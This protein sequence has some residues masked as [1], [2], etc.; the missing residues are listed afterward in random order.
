MDYPW[1]IHSFSMDPETTPKHTIYTYIYIYVYICK[2]FFFQNGSLWESSFS[3]KICLDLTTWTALPSDYKKRTIGTKT[4][5]P[6]ERKPSFPTHLQGGGAK[7]KKNIEKTTKNQ[8]PWKGGSQPRLSEYCVFCVSFCI[9]VFLFVSMF[10]WF[11]PAPLAEG[12]ERLC[13][14]L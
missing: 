14:F 6:K 12:G 5:V 2:V 4:A 13:L 1:I 11:L 7:P 10:F 9:F 3:E 8:T